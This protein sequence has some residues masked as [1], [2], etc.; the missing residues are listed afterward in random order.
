MNITFK[1]SPNYTPGR[2]KPITK[3]VIHWMAGTLA[4]T[5]AQF[6]NPQSEVSAHYGI[7]ND[8]IHQYVREGDTAWHARQANPYTIGIEHSAAPGRNATESTINTS[9]RL[10]ADI[11][12]R[13]NIPINRGNVIKHSEV[14]NTLCSG[15]IPIDEIINKALALQK[16]EE[17][18]NEGDS[19]NVTEIFGEGDKQR[20]KGQAWSAVF[21]NYLQGKIKQQKQ[22]LKN[23]TDIAN[24]RLD[25]INDLLSDDD[26]AEVKLAKIE[27]IIKG[28]T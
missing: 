10:L 1:Q 26:N 19:Y 23:A 16:G 25:Q 18:L 9:A 27:Q 14:V 24:I 4:S 7:E 21:Y 17:M 22:D 6:A 20:F 15:T 2:T 13:H 8:I 12:S 3:V 5:D 28:D 11:C